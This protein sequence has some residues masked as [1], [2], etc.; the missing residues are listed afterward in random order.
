MIETTTGI[1]SIFTSIASK[2]EQ[3]NSILTF[4]IDKSWRKKAI[5]LCQLKAGDTVLDLCCGTGQMV[6]Y[7]CKIVGKNAQVIGLDF[8]DAM[9]NEAHKK[10]KKPLKGYTYQIMKGNVLELP[11]SD[12]SF[13]CITIAFGIRNIKDKRKVLSEM[14]RVVKP[15]G[16]VICLE[17]SKPEM[18][19]IKNIYAIYFNHLLPIIGYVG[20]QDR[21]AYYYL[22]NS[23]NGFMKKNELKQEFDA[24]GFQNT[25]YISLTFGVASIHYGKK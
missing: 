19:I 1:D 12:H 21:T 2:Y 4:N 24:V 18:P 13:D 20:T 14:Y 23:V 22:R 16:N 17:L 15:G 5:N 8:N 10:L 9:I 7:A 25:D 3:L 6:E 11:F